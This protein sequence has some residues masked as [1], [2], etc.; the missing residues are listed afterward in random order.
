MTS[1]GQHIP[2]LW[3]LDYHTLF[4]FGFFSAKLHPT[5]VISQLR[6]KLLFYHKKSFNNFFLYAFNFIFTCHYIIAFILRLFDSCVKHWMQFVLSGPWRPV[7]VYWFVWMLM[8]AFLVSQTQK[9]SSHS[10]KWSWTS[11]ISWNQVIWHGLPPPS[12]VDYLV[13][14]RIKKKRTLQPKTETTKPFQHTLHTWLKI[15]DP[16]LSA[17]I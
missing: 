14:E 7:S 5:L 10:L 8:F 11:W 1:R 6:T 3:R 12:R 13:Y 4:Q 2:N 17:H 16:F 9:E 15:P